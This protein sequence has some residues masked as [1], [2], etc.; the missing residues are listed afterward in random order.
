MLTQGRNSAQGG[1]FGDTI[2]MSLR[3]LTSGGLPQGANTGI[4]MLR[5]CVCMYMSGSL[6]H[7]ANT[8]I[9]MLRV[10]VCMYVYV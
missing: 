3:P 8:D 2:A 4:H 10:Y 6:P 9:C 1:S 5:V 7:V